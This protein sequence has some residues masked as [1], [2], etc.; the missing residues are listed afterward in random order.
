MKAIWYE[1]S[2]KAQDVLHYGDMEQPEPRYR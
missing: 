2:G 1:Q